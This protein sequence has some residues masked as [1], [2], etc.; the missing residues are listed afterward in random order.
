MEWELREVLEI[1][2]KRDCVAG[3]VAMMK[4]GYFRCVP[5]SSCLSTIVPDAL[6]FHFARVSP[7]QW[8]LGNV[9]RVYSADD[10]A[11]R[12]RTEFKGLCS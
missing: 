2:N 8:D 7:K 1:L 11:S 6:S 9:D 10:W 4:K 3:F 5:C 12:K